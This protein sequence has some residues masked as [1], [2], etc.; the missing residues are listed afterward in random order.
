MQDPTEKYRT[1]QQIAESFGV[2]KAT[3][4]RIAK[5]NDIGTP[6]GATKTRFFTKSDIA[7]LKQICRFRKGNPNF[8]KKTS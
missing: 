3:I 4:N 7:K 1:A 8:S 5:T 2:N 6:I